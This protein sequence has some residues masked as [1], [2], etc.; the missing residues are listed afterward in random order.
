MSKKLYLFDIEGTTTDINFVHKVLFPYASENL[1]KFVLENQNNPA[2]Q[3]A[4]EDTRQTIITE[5]GLTPSLEQSIEK[6][7]FWIKSDRKHSALKELQGLIWDE[8]YKKGDFKGHLYSDVKPFFDRI[9]KNG[10]EI[11]IYSSGSVLA[12]K[13]IFGYSVEG[14]LTGLISFYFDTKVGGK[15]EAKS[16]ENIVEAT[17]YK[18]SDIIFFSDIYEENLAAKAA[19]MKTYQLLRYPQPQRE[20][21]TIPDFN[22]LDRL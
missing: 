9:K 8:G 11:G 19:G 2:V 13:L 21:E 18:A 3:K 6:L 14:D 5:D 20:I 22:G 16:Y 1:S 15:R 10:E 4:I 17:K 7:L 12:Q